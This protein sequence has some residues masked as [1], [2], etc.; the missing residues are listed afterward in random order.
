MKIAFRW[1]KLA[2]KESRVLSSDL[3]IFD[4]RKKADKK[5]SCLLP[6]SVDDSMDDYMVVVIDF[7][8]GKGIVLVTVDNLLDVV[9]ES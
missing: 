7:D 3:V 6:G 5:K 2:E 8:D 4:D 1:K 9:E